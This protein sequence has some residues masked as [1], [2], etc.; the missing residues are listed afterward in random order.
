[1]NWCKFASSAIAVRETIESVRRFSVVKMNESSQL[2]WA[3]AFLTKVIARR[4]S[5]KHFRKT[6][7]DMQFL[8]Q[9]DLFCTSSNEH[10]RRNRNH[11]NRRI[12]AEHLSQKAP[13]PGTLQRLPDRR[14]CGWGSCGNRRCKLLCIDGHGFDAAQ[15]LAEEY[16]CSAF[17]S[18]KE[19]LTTFGY[20]IQAL[21][22]ATPTFTHEECIRSAV[23]AGKHIFTEKPLEETPDA[24]GRLFDMIDEAGL[25]LLCGFQHRFD[26]SYMALY[27]AVREDSAENKIGKP[28][29]H[30]RF[31][32]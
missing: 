11:G 18:V 23:P 9:G 10:R 6:S 28:A 31:L 8:Q 20:Q 22:I 24:I 14:G 30:Q 19:V 29:L 32:R 16:H 7:N 2:K 3:K 1:M 26:A 15:T 25:H 5:G 12:P 4:R 21:W 13:M 17:S 27:D